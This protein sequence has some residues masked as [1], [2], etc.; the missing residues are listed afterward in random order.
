MHAECEGC[1]QPAAS[2][3]GGIRLVLDDRD[4]LRATV[5]AGGSVL[6]CDRCWN[7]L[8]DA[9]LPADLAADMAAGVAVAVHEDDG[10]VE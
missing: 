5:A 1:G 2:H 6:L 8:Q 3:F 10:Q 7:K 4:R 9:H